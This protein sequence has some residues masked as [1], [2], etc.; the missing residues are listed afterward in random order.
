MPLK[1]RTERKLARKKCADFW[2][3]ERSCQGKRVYE[4]WN[5]ASDAAARVSLITRGVMHAYECVL[6]SSD[7]KRKFHTG[8]YRLNR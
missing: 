8:H 3:Y 5:E 2:S 7:E 6:C 1:R 4:D